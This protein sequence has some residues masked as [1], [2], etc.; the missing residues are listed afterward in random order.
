M[1]IWGVVGSVVIENRRVVQGHCQIDYGSGN[2]EGGYTVFQWRV[3][4]SNGGATSSHF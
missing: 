4:E 3:G 2:C 1:T